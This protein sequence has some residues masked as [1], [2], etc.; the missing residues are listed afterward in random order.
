MKFR[1]LPVTRDDGGGDG[2][3]DSVRGRDGGGGSGCGGDGG[4]IKNSA[5][6][7]VHG[8]EQRQHYA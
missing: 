4:N 1:S 5:N 8:S 6:P 7:S 3:D 2:K